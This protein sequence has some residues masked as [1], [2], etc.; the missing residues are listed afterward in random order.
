MGLEALDVQISYITYGPHN[1][2]EALIIPALK[3]ATCYKRSVGFFSTS[4]FETILD[5]VISLAHRKGQ[6]Q[7]ITSPE[8]SSE[9]IEAISLGYK[10]RNSVYTSAF[11]QNFEQVLYDLSDE[12]LQITV[13]LIVNKI[14]DIR[15][16]DFAG[17]NTEAAGL[18]HDKLGIISDASNN[19]IVFVGSPNETLNGYQKNYEKVRVFKSWEPGQNAYVIDEVKEFDRLWEGKN[20]YLKT[21]SFQDAL[22]AHVLKVKD[23]REAAKKAKGPITL[24]KYQ[25]D[26]INAWINNGYH[27]FFVMATGTGKTWTAIYASDALRKKHACMIVIAAPYKH[28]G[29]KFLPLGGVNLGNLKEM[30]SDPLI[31]AV[32]GSWIAKESMISAGDFNTIRKNAADA[33]KVISELGNC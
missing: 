10:A 27:G 18:Y 1:I 12:K 9:D 7:I 20:S 8:L 28:L 21:Y 14:L 5:G 31:A 22:I 16:V 17:G 29:V 33:A 4:V 13:E 26:A 32:G 3:A 2:R 6:I 30:L 15:I 11:L 25:N 19:T 24:R 23:A